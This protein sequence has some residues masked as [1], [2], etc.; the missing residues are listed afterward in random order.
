MFELSKQD[1][2]AARTAADLQRRYGTK[3][4]EV[5]ETIAEA[6]DASNAVGRLDAELTQK[7]I[8]RRLTNNGA[9]QGMFMDEMGDIYVNASFVA[10]GTLMSQNKWLKI[11]LANGRMTVDCYDPKTEFYM[12]RQIALGKL[13][14]GDGWY[15]G[16]W[17]I[18]EH[19]DYPNKHSESL[20][21]DPQMYSG[22]RQIPVI[23]GF[24]TSLLLAA[25][26]TDPDKSYAVRIGENSA[27]VVYIN[28][29]YVQWEWNPTYGK[30]LLVGHDI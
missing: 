2:Q 25:R 22:G 9:A 28:G 20:L 14:N 3:F 21:I 6:E 29:K 15:E 7:E 1:R 26:S 10:T 16:L 12:D 11:D 17:G 18:G 13:E 5:M 27:S 24:D 8:F 23:W 4:S 19:Y 30:Y